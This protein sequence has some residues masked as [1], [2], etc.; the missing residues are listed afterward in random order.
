MAGA[1]SDGKT[2]WK[3]GAI[4]DRYVHLKP[5]LQIARILPHCGVDHSDLNML[6]LKARQAAP[7][8]WLWLAERADARC[9]ISMIGPNEG[10]R[11]ALNRK[12]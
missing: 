10:Q 1:I 4:D 6:F 7:Q 9:H 8:R 5:L 12:R 2:I 11:A 3:E